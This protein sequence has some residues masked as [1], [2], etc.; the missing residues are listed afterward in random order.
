MTKV[1]GQ[2][3]QPPAEEIEKAHLGGH[4][5]VRRVGPNGEALVWCRKCS[6][7]ARC[8]RGLKLMDRCRPEKR[9]TEGYGKTVNI[10]FKVEEGEVPHR[11]AKGW[12]LEGEKKELQGTSARGQ[13]KNLKLEVP[14]HKKGCVKKRMLPKEEG[15]LI[16]KYKAMHQDSVPSWLRDDTEGKEEDVE[17]NEQGSQMRGE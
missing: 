1:A 15:D 12:K 13:W 8:R 6:G 5:M 7:H 2:G 11:N 16:R 4:D 17:K 9:D 14:W 10:N 3:L